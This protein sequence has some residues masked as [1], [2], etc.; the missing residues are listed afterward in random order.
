[1]VGPSLALALLVTAPAP[2]RGLAIVGATL[3]DASGTIEDGIV[4]VS[5]GR[6]EAAGPRAHVPLAKGLELQN[7]RGLFV[8]PG[9][10]WSAAAAAALK[11][12]RESVL[13]ALRARDARW[14]AGRPADL[15][16]LDKDPL[17]DPANLRAVVRVLRGGREMQPSEAREAER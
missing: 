4:V 2:G 16:V 6:V 1:M 10:P 8:M 9:P 15:V 17:A 5:Q 3:V 14:Q 11:G 7:G 13:A 12:G